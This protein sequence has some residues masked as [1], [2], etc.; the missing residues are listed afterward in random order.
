MNDSDFGYMDTPANGYGIIRSRTLVGNLRIW[1]IP[2][3]AQALDIV[4]TEIAQSRVPG[5][6]LLFDDKHKKKVYIGQSENLR[7]RLTTHMQAPDPKIQNWERA[8]VINDARNAS[9]SDLN[10]ENIRLTLENY[11]V[12]LFKI[13]RYKVTTTSSRNPSLGA[14][15]KTLANSFKNEI[16]VLLT[17]KNRITKVLTERGDDEDYNDTVKK[18]LESKGHRL[19]KWG[20]LDATVDSQKTFIRPGSYKPKGWQVTFRGSK[21]TSLKP[22]LESGEGYLI[23]PRGPIL[24]IPLNELKQFI[25]A[26][27]S[28]AFARDTIDIFIRFDEE[29]I[30]V[31]YK[32]NEFDVT[33]FAIDDFL[34]N[35]PSESQASMTYGASQESDGLPEHLAADQKYECPECG[36]SVFAKDITC[37]KCGKKLDETNYTED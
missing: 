23:M 22:H 37:P 16:I 36:Q 9:Q 29:K 28:D 32:G 26:N 17:K 3:E 4:M 5:L 10:D 33:H 27:D 14:T 11:L 25:K 35:T 1:D 2:R 12:Q 19:S 30:V 21:P 6:Y 24:L 18:K 34:L 8:I 13:N 20:K 31:V 7:S 15:Q